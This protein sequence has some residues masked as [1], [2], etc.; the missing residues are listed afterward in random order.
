[1][2]YS[3]SFSN[4]KRD[5]A[6]IFSTVISEEPRFISNFKNSGEAIHR[7]HEWMDDRL[8]GRAITATAGN[9]VLTVSPGDSAKLKNGTLIAL[10]DDSA[11]FAVEN[12]NGT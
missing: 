1:M 8:S 10:K 6:D 4:R 5:L 11:L 2:L 3:Y 9:G 12:I 7:K